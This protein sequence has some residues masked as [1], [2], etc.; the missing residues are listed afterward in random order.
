MI[1][2]PIELQRIYTYKSFPL[3]LYKNYRRRFQLSQK[4]ELLIGPDKISLFDRPTGEL[5]NE[6]LHAEDTSLLI[7]RQLIYCLLHLYDQEHAV[8]TSKAWRAISGWE[9]PR[10]P[11]FAL[12][13]W[14][15]DADNQ[16]VRAYAH[17]SGLQNVREDFVTTA[18]FY[19]LPP[20]STIE[21]SVKCRTPKKFEFVAALFPEFK[22]PLDLP[23]IE[24]CKMETCFLDDFVFFDPNNGKVIDIGPVN[25][26][27]VKGFEVLYA[28]PGVD[29]VAEIA[30]HL[31]LRIKLD[32]NE[33]AKRLGIENPHDLV[34]SF[35]ADTGEVDD[36]HPSDPE[37]GEIDITVECK[38]NWF[39]IVNSDPDGD[40]IESVIQSL[41]GLSGGFLTVMDRQTLAQ[42]VKSYT[43]EQDRNLQR[44][45]LNL[46]EAQKESLLNRL[47]IAKKNYKSSYYFFSKNC[48]S[49]LMKVIAQGIGNDAIAHF[50]PLVSPP[51]TLIGLLLKN[52]IATPVYPSFYS[53][54][55][56][57]YIAQEILKEEYQSLVDAFPDSRWPDVDRL[58]SKDDNVRANAVAQLA[59]IIDKR[60]ETWPRAYF[61][62]AL[63]Q[64]A[65]MAFSYKGLVCKRYTTP[66]TAE[67]R[68]LQRFILSESRGGVEDFQIPMAKRIEGKY[69]DIEK[70]GAENGSSHTGH[71]AFAFGAGG[72]FSDK[73]QCT[74]VVTL[75]AALHH[76]DMGAVSSIAMQRSG[77]VDLGKVTAVCEA[78]GDEAGK[79]KSW[80]VTALSLRKFK[81]RLNRVP[82]YFS[83]AGTFGIG[84][85]VIDFSGDSELEKTYG[86]LAGV[87]ALFNMFSSE[88]NNRFLY[89]SGG[90][91]IVSNGY[92]GINSIGIGLPLRTEALWTFDRHRKWQWRGEA[93]YEFSTRKDISDILQAET[94][95]TFRPEIFK[96]NEVLIRF[97]VRFRRD[98]SNSVDPEDHT[99]SM[100]R[101]E[102][103]VHFW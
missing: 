93:A 48:A 41:K 35:L 15:K 4:T 16:D 85:T 55:K 14:I 66:A 9:Y 2:L 42:T 74:P 31:L 82:S 29:D 76:Q 72:Y 7:N 17:P 37:N 61:L 22:S 46:S 88:E 8:S 24:C 58:F 36:P 67:A 59:Q 38:K 95:I 97:A 64:E 83:S 30:G 6:A 43:I 53:Y 3:K 50:D 13:F 71:N 68:C 102:A 21:A 39:N 25:M 34:I 75:D 87:E 62:A 70:S 73:S 28:T 94:S 86:T 69:R 90:G 91:S 99:T 20:N 103:E 32:N 57:G 49:V 33:R 56:K 26:D 1:S 101:I 98:L 54:R 63:I 47:F 23:H 51:N 80:R 89:I 10:L 92:K 11:G 27:T 96:K 19:I 77:Y 12:P 18:L 84:L 81:D 78:H 52:G 45:A 100:G 40:A 79:L 60:R 5:F 44:Y 65:E